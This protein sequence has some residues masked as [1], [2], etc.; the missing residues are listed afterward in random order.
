VLEVT[1][2]LLTA[3]LR[4]HKEYLAFVAAILLPLALYLLTLSPTVQGRDSAELATGSYVL[5]IVHATGYPLYLLLG[6]LFSYLPI[7]DVAYRINLMSAVFAALTC[8]SVYGITLRLTRS[9]WAALLGAL[10]LGFSFYFWQ[11][12]VVAE[13]YTL[14]TFLIGALLWLLLRWDEEEVDWLLYVFAL[15]YGLSLGNHITGILLGL[16]FAYWVL[17]KGPGRVLRWRL[18]GGMLLC[19]LLGLAIYLYLPI[20]YLADPPLNYVQSYYGVDLTTPKGV[21]WMVSGQMYRFFAFGYTLGEVEQELVKHLGWLW[22]NFLGVG[23]V[24]GI[25]GLFSLFQSRRRWVIALLLMLIP[26]VAFFANYRVV[27]KEGMFLPAHFLWA[28]LIP[29]GCLR[30][31]RWVSRLGAV[32]P[33]GTD[34]RFAS[35]LLLLAVMGLVAT[36]GSA[37]YRHADR[38]DSWEWR[39]SAEQAL[40]QIEPNAVVASP[41]ST[42][43]VLE[44]MQVVEG[45]R[46]DIEVFN[47][48]RY[49]VAQFYHHCR[50]VDHVGNCRNRLERDESRFLEAQAKTRPVYYLDLDPLGEDSGPYEPGPAISIVKTPNEQLVIK[51]STVN[52]EIRVTNTGDRQLTEVSVSDPLAPD[53]EREFAEIVAGRSVS[54]QC[55]VQGVT[56][57]FTNTATVEAVDPMGAP[58]SPDSD[59]AFVQAGYGLFLPLVS[60]D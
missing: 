10:F 4:R 43:V 30:I 45:Y 9:W 37:N 58:V 54:Y 1:S 49:S 23:V 40:A 36:Q 44:Y 5:G 12:A 19:F 2:K 39:Q 7:G 6:K 50:G 15:L 57:S 47:R 20:R 48:S 21:L 52:F 8:G 46:P 22:R 42:A 29:A 41:W 28:L 33:S 34:R 55:G 26:T 16:G 13:V 31:T 18:A 25:V 17:S 60:K 53:C 3:Q 11:S 51:G 35:A 56:E 24:A 59:T 38:S 27:D 32:L 14:Q